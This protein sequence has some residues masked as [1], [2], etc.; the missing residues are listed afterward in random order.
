MRIPC[1][2]PLIIRRRPVGGSRPLI[3]LPLVATDQ[4]DLLDQA[5]R[6]AALATDLVEWRVDGF[7]PLPEPE[8]LP[9]ILEALRQAIGDLPLLFTC[10]RR[11]E[12]GLQ[13]IISEVRLAVALAAVASGHADLVDAELANPEP[14]VAA[15]KDACRRQGVRLI[16]SFHDF[17]GTP[18]LGT[19]VARLE[20]ARTRGADIAKAAVM[21][22]G[23][24]DVLTLLE[25][26]AESRRRLPDTPLIPIAMGPEGVLARIIGGLFGADVTFAAGPRS[27]APGQIDIAELRAAWRALGLLEDGPSSTG[28]LS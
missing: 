18:D 2:P 19:I 17:A 24:R 22:R 7:M 15:L 23:P 12:G 10:R 4:T 25:A 20:E 27:S 14:M 9:A 13:S 28:F 26:S 11:A 16:L 8:A 3:C 1:Q 5:R 6:A 21:A